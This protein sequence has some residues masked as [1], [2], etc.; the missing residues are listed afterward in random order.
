MATYN[1]GAAGNFITYT[2]QSGSTLYDSGGPSSNY[3]D[4]EN[5]YALIAPQY[6]TG[7]LTLN[8][9]EEHTSELQSH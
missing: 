2:D 9:S 5:F 1:L 3:S 8:R 6:A 7:T 4:S